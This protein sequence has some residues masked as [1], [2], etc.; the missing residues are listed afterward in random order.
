MRFCMANFDIVSV[1]FLT[2]Q[3]CLSACRQP[4]ASSTAAAG[5]LQPDRSG[6]A[7][8]SPASSWHSRPGGMVWQQ[9]KPRTFLFD[10]LVATNGGNVASLRAAAAEWWGSTRLQNDAPT[11]AAALTA[12]EPD[13]VV[14]R[15]GI[16]LADPIT[17][18]AEQVSANVE[19]RTCSEV[20]GNNVMPI[21][22]TC[23]C[24]L[25]EAAAAEAVRRRITSPWYA[26]AAGVRGT[27]AFLFFAISVIFARAPLSAEQKAKTSG[28]VLL[29]AG[30]S[31]AIALAGCFYAWQCFSYALEAFGIRVMLVGARPFAPL[32]LPTLMRWFYQDAAAKAIIEYAQGLNDSAAGTPVPRGQAAPDRHRRRR[33]LY[34]ATP[35]ACRAALPGGSQADARRLRT[36]EHGAG[37]DLRSAEAHVSWREM[38]AENITATT[39]CIT[40]CSPGW[41]RVA[42]LGMSLTLFAGWWILFIGSY[43][44]AMK[45]LDPRPLSSAASGTGSSASE[46]SSS[47][48]EQLHA[49]ADTGELVNTIAAHAQQDGPH[50]QSCNAG[51][52]SQPFCMT[53]TVR[54]V[55]TP[56]QWSAR[57]APV[58]GVAVKLASP[59]QGQ[60][61]STWYAQACMLAMMIAVA[62]HLLLTAPYAWMAPW[63]E[64]LMLVAGTCLSLGSPATALLAC[65]VEREQIKRLAE[66]LGESVARADAERRSNEARQRL[67]RY[68]FHEVRVPFS[69][70]K[71]ALEALTTE[72]QLTDEGVETLQMA[73]SSAESM[74]SILNNVMQLSTLEAHAFRIDK[75]RGDVRHL[76]RSV[77]FQMRPWANNIRAHLSIDV[78]DSVP[79]GLLFDGPRLCQVLSNFVGN[80]L[81]WVDQ[82]GGGVVRVHA[83]CSKG[84]SEG[85]RSVA[86]ASTSTPGVSASSSLSDAEA[87]PS[88]G[89]MSGGTGSGAGSDSD[90]AASGPIRIVRIAVIDNGVGINK[91]ERAK[92]FTA[93][94]QISSGTAA[95]GKRVQGTGLGLAIAKEIVTHHGGKVGCD[96]EVGKGSTFWI[97]IPMELAEDDADAASVDAPPA[98][99]HPSQLIAPPSVPHH[100]L[101]TPPLPSLRCT[102]T[103]SPT[104]TTSTATD[105]SRARALAGMHAASESRPMPSML[106]PQP[107]PGP[108]AGEAPVACTGGQSKA[109]GPG[110]ASDH[111]RGVGTSGSS[112]SGAHNHASGTVPASWQ[113]DRL[114]A[115]MHLNGTAHTQSAGEASDPHPSAGA[116]SGLRHHMHGSTHASAEFSVQHGSMHALQRIPEPP[117]ADSGSGMDVDDGGTGV[118]DRLPGPSSI[119]ASTAGSPAQSV[120][121][122]SPAI[123]S[124]SKPAS[125]HRGS[126]SS[127]LTPSTG[128]TTASRHT[129]GSGRSAAFVPD[130]TDRASAPDLHLYSSCRS[131]ATPRDA[132]SKPSPANMLRLLLVDDDPN[133]RRLLSRLLKK[134]YQSRGCV[135]DEAD[136]G[137]IALDLVRKAMTDADHVRMHPSSEASPGPS[138]GYDVIL[139]DGN[140]PVMDGYQAT[141]RIRALEGNHS[142]PR[143]RTPIIGITGNGLAEDIR[144]FKAAGA[145]E[146]MVKPVCIN[147][148]AH[149]I[150]AGYL[151]AHTCDEARSATTSMQGQQLTS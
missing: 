62:S 125:S 6:S 123:T 145:D 138:H 132:G 104:V 112:E 21:V 87:V 86:D 1:C 79:T 39:I 34:N 84:Q 22:Q 56:H 94:H 68:V 92:L 106:R 9:S 33:R 60:S 109:A 53:S 55:T 20:G 113:D 105:S 96:S 117:I 144:A 18:R 149:A 129:L 93:F 26:L 38:I 4:P 65:V 142:P 114:F 140:M 136:N 90:A 49:A 31:C 118:A 141:R 95:T 13:Q 25:V 7:T 85:R 88:T 69:A 35:A 3:G 63:A 47:T 24:Y 150:E 75:C 82:Q 64:V 98:S 130:E 71:L 122:V 120:P 133:N 59:V 23:D 41:T 12:D 66:K 67:L 78:D 80:A 30:P 61:V 139:M 57:S 81:K 42:L 91:Q 131:A 108:Q 127:H 29:S 83:S 73:R 74:T 116:G 148:L 40:A 51:I 50:A 17:V 32:P 143:C 58:G 36:T 16:C 89:T 28:Q 76:L 70:V 99:L 43:S 45:Q 77:E 102:S 126:E 147:A 107:Q 100:L 135:C 44:G 128:R 151:L 54:C 115:G 48:R 134:R 5:H 119:S 8:W 97:E 11:Q 111:V 137:Q 72:P 27:L 19:P 2:V 103:G 121:G 110:G 101:V 124:T 146:V 10:F 37:V 15:T 14:N 52:P 46:N